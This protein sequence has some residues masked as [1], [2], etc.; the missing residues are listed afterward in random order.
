M[1]T[2]PKNRNRATISVVG[3][4]YNILVIHAKLEMLIELQRIIGLKDSFRAV[5]GESSIADKDAKA[6]CREIPACCI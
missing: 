4:I 1:H 2:E 3:W 6:A 5:I